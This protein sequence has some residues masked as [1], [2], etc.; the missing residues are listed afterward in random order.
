MRAGCIESSAELRRSRRRLDAEEGDEMGFFSKQRKV[1]D[2]YQQ[3]RDRALSLD[4]TEIGLQPDQSNPVYGILMETAIDDVVVTLAAIGDGSVSL[5]FSN[6]GGMIGMG[7]HEGPR[8]ACLSFLSFAAQFTSHLKP[9]REFPLPQKGYATFYFLTVT[10]VLWSNTRESDL[11]KDRHPLSPLFHKGQEVIAEARLVEE[12]RQRAF[13][14]IMIAVT[15][16]DAAGLKAL[17]ENGANLS[18]SDPTGLTP[19]MAASHAGNVE[20]LK[21]LL[22]TGVPID[23][24]DSSGYTA[25]MFSCNSGQLLCARYLVEKGA[26]VNES[27]ND[28]STPIMFCAQHG[29]NDIVKL[30]LENGADPKIQGA[31]GLSAIGFAKQNGRTETEKIL[32]SAS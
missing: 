9:T 14:D 24:K 29:H 20:V 26:K 28:G 7:E 4:P 5:Y 31:H 3:L 13:Q 32:Q 17:F 11:A 21:F 27:A 30:L 19:L 15:T 8:K 23:T 12:K 16:G 25:L 1:A 22:E 2:I 6:G 18:A 10:G